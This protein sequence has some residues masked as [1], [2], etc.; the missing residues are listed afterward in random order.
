M[1][2]GVW[3]EAYVCHCNW[4]ALVSVSLQE[5]LSGLRG[6]P[7][8]QTRAGTDSAERLRKAACAS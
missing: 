8:A 2:L 6:A 3:Q 7:L 4:L 5:L 1:F